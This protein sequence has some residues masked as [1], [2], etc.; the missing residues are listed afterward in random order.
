MRDGICICIHYMFVLAV[1]ITAFLHQRFVADRASAS[2]ILVKK[3]LASVLMYF[4]RQG[5]LWPHDIKL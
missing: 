2:F 4:A 1:L 5:A 3:A